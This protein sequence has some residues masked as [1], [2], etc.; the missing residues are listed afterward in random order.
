MSSFSWIGLSSIASDDADKGSS[1]GDTGADKDV[2]DALTYNAS[3]L[4]IRET[5]EANYEGINRCNQALNIVPQLDQANPALRSRL[6]GEAKFLRA[7]MYFTLVKH[8]AEFLLLIIYQTL[9]L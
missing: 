1:P 7:F 5:F 9:L 2:M 8:M 3:S 6:I 4:S